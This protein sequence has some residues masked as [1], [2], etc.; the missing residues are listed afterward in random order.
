MREPNVIRLRGPWEYSPLERSDSNDPLPA[1]G[2]QTMPAD[3]SSTLGANFRGRV[4]Y[5][6]RFGKPGFTEPYEQL[7][8]VCQQVRSR[9]SVLLNGEV[10][11]EVSGDQPGIF[12]VTDKLAFRNML[13]LVVEH[14]AGAGEAGGIVGDVR[15]EIL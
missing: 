1:S 11:G 13:E 8:I 4:R 2:K 10:L 6:R 7:W 3:W 14:P 9:A 12:E 15:L 5:L